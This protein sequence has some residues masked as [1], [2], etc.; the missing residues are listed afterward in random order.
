MRKSINKLTN[1]EL[2]FASDTSWPLLKRSVLE[3]VQEELHDFAQ[4]LALSS[5]IL[6]DYK[7][8]KGDNLQGVPYLVLD[9]PRIQNGFT[10]VCRTLF[11]WGHHISH[12]ILIH[13]SVWGEASLDWIL[14]LPSE[15]RILM[16][17]DAIWEPDITSDMYMDIG[18]LQEHHLQ[19]LGQVEWIKVGKVMAIADIADMEVQ[20][21]PFVLDVLKRSGI[22]KGA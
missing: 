3:K 8:S 2:N 7:I 10:W 22:K 11:W 13:R 6:Q 1:H 21:L 4:V 16:Q 14:H 15:T 18:Q 12:T 19:Q 9:T 5:E 20:G 17:E